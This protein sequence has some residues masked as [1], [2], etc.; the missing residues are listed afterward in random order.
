V[1]WRP[2]VVAEDEAAHRLTNFGYTTLGIITTLCL[3]WVGYSVIA[4]W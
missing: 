3:L 1:S 4:Q 2:E